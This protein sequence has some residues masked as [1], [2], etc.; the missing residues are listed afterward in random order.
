MLLLFSLAPA[1][2]SFHHAGWHWR[3]FWRLLK[4]LEKTACICWYSKGA[5]S[6]PCY[7]IYTKFHR[8]TG[9]LRLLILRKSK[10]SANVR[11]RK[12]YHGLVAYLSRKLDCER[13]ANVEGTE[14]VSWPCRVPLQKP[15]LR[16]SDTLCANKRSEYVGGT[17]ATT[18]T[19]SRASRG[20]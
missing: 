13:S 20:S 7:F 4:T 5:C 6:S 15:S 8:S 14:G 11:V 12:E 3:S 9:T 17:G 16:D 18:A 1:K 2:V 19:F 10:I